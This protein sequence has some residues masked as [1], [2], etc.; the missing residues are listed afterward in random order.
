MFDYFD[1]YSNNEFQ[2]VLF[3][4]D[5]YDKVIIL[6]YDLADLPLVFRSFVRLV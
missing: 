6:A 5:L 1:R 4:D 3:F 2:A